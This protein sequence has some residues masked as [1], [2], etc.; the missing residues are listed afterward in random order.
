MKIRF[1]PAVIADDP[2]S[3]S[4]GEVR[5]SLA[6][7]SSLFSVDPYSGWVTTIG[8]LDRE[9]MP[10]H[11]L[12]ILATDAGLTKRTSRGTLIVRL[13]DYNDCPPVFKQELYTAEVCTIL[14]EGVP[15]S[16]FS[17]KYAF[18]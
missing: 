8:E 6:E 4:N 14:P 17:Q 13:V 10:E 3:G 18:G 12:G 15:T 1:V 11:R 16:I 5:Y 2:D 9:T 7:E